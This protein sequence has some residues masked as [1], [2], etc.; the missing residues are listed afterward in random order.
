MIVVKCGLEGLP[1]CFV[2]VEVRLCVNGNRIC[3][4]FCDDWDVV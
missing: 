2:V 4:Y 3:R 1:I